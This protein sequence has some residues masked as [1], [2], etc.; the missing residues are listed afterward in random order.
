MIK[1]IL[2]DLGNVIVPIDFDRCHAAFSEVSSLPPAEIPARLRP[3]GLGERF[4]TGRMSP[5]EFAD[6]V[7]AA[8]GMRAGYPQFWEIW[9]TIFLPV[10]LL[11][12][13]LLEGLRRRQRLVLLSNTNAVHFQYAQERYPLL[14]HFD[15]FVLSYRVGATKPSPAIYREAVA[16]AGCRPEECFFT[17]DVGKF[18]E[19]ARREGIDA[20][21][22]QSQGQLEAELANRGITW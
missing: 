10:P 14:R 6:E 21:Q 9:S 17:D 20:V 2:L 7:C 12:E 19:A 4:E 11:S 8:L 22:F 1:A 13:S 3:T 15:D 16:R 5:E 18:V